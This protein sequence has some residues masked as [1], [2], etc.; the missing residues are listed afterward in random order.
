MI[1]KLQSFSRKN[2]VICEGNDDTVSYNTL[3]FLSSF[4]NCTSINYHVDFRMSEQL[5]TTF[6][7]KVRVLTVLHTSLSLWLYYLTDG[8]F[9]SIDI[10]IGVYSPMEGDMNW[11]YAQHWWQNRAKS[12][13]RSH[14]WLNIKIKCGIN[15]TKLSMWARI[16]EFEM[17]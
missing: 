11:M 1:T 7:Y 13:V 6:N 9:I 12:K 3:M 17:L 14:P 4:D 10:F 8:M 5:L 2:T 16:V 15:G